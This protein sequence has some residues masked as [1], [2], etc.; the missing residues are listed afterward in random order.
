MLLFAALNILQKKKTIFFFSNTVILNLN[1]REWI[2]RFF[3]VV[4]CLFKI[5]DIK[6]HTNNLVFGC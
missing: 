1:K 3:V 2:V 4:F 5:N 6:K